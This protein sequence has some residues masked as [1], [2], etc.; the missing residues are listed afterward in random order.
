MVFGYRRTP[1]EAGSRAFG[2]SSTPRKSSQRFD[3]FLPI[4]L[5]ATLVAGQILGAFGTEATFLDRR[6]RIP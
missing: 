1:Q 4:L 5:N 3:F 6:R 2:L